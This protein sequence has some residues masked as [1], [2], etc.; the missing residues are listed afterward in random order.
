MSLSVLNDKFC[1]LKRVHPLIATIDNKLYKKSI[2]EKLINTQNKKI[3]SLKS[4]SSKYVNIKSLISSNAE[5]KNVYDNLNINS[6]KNMKT[7]ESRQSLNYKNILTENKSINFDSIKSSENLDL[8]I[9]KNNFL[10]NKKIP[11]FNSLLLNG[12]KRLKNETLKMNKSTNV[13]NEKY[14]F[15]NESNNTEINNINKNIGPEKKEK[16]SIKNN[17][18]DLQS[19]LIDKQLQLKRNKFPFKKFLISKTNYNNYNKRKK[20]KMNFIANIKS[21]D[22]RIAK[23]KTLDTLLYKTIS[24]IRKKDLSKK[25][26]SMESLDNN[27]IWNDYTKIEKDK[28]KDIERDKLYMKEKMNNLI[29]I[30]KNSYSYKKY[31]K[32]GIKNEK[33]KYLNFLDD[34]SLSLRVNFIKNNLQN[35]RGG[36]QNLRVTYNPLIK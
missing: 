24:K 28:S 32:N 35:D 8:P 14:K 13:S 10:K 5:K 27:S 34:Y 11:N 16:P 36:K 33:E 6:L 20:L 18:N 21:L 15:K 2:I 19:S 3:F 12:K 26:E 31:K 1:K 29:K 30:F 25:D 4:S 23:K 7:D 17:N 22:S 9:L